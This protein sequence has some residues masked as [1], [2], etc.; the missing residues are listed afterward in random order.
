[1]FSWND[2]TTTTKFLYYE[3]SCVFYGRF[4]G[5]EVVL[6]FLNQKH[7]SFLFLFTVHFSISYASCHAAKI[8]SVQYRLSLMREWK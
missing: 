6:L 4:F 5:R 2:I 8:E 1:M 7:T 3:Q